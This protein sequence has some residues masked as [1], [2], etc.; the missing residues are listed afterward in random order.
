MRLLS[1]V[2]AAIVPSE[3]GP[4][5]I[6]AGA[7]R[8]ITME[9]DLQ[10]KTQV[11]L[12]LFEKEIQPW[13]TRFSEDVKTAIDIGADQGE[14]TIYFLRRKSCKTVLSFEPETTG[15]PLLKSNLALNDLRNDPR[16][17]LSSKFVGDRDDD[18]M[19]TLDSI[20]NSTAGPYVVKL[21]VDG[22]ETS[23]LRGA[24][25]F[26]ASGVPSRWIIETH[27]KELEDECVA[28]LQQA[29]FST[30]IVPNAWWRVILPELRPPEHNQW[31]V[32]TNE[33]GRL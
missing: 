32:A 14:Y 25:Q 13:L 11:L 2:K 21:D 33:S 22:G 28:V 23:V 20:T 7:F 16:L 12:G 15:W 31:L 27:S 5:T 19:C 17:S 3:S 6:K 4:H 18:R 30:R 1:T 26:L 29:G 24:R 10:H 9:M 8:G